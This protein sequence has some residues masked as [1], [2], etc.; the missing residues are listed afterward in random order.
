[1]ISIRPELDYKKL[2]I[3]TL[4]PILD[5]TSPSGIRNKIISRLDFGGSGLRWGWNGFPG[6]TDPY[7]NSRLVVN[8]QS[9]DAGRILLRGGIDIYYMDRNIQIGRLDRWREDENLIHGVETEGKDEDEVRAL[10][11]TSLLARCGFYTSYDLEPLEN[12]TWKVTRESQLG[13]PSF[14]GS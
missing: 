6:A 10:I 7:G 13:P 1:M 5:F 11:T 9:F 12:N 8:V 2:P 3:Q 4:E 14:S